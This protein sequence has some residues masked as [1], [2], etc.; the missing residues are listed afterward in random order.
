MSVST[1]SFLSLFSCCFLPSL[2]R[3]FAPRIYSP[4]SS[5]R[6]L[7]F[8]LLPLK[9]MLTRATESVLARLFFQPFS[10]PYSPRQRVPFPS[11]SSACKAV[12]S[13]RAKQIW[14]TRRTHDSSAGLSCSHLAVTGRY[15][16]TSVHQERRRAL[17]R[18]R[19][20][21]RVFRRCSCSLDTSSYS[22]GDT[23]PHLRAQA[24]RA[25]QQRRPTSCTWRGAEP[26]GRFCVNE[27][28]DYTHPFRT[29]NL[30]VRH[31]ASS[32]LTGSA[33]GSSKARC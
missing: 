3:V 30:A 29:E 33:S 11:S 18:P 16:D 1:V 32:V 17:W 20:W 27:S 9:L 6:P 24:R 26:Q 28:R 4:L 5:S 12:P 7:E 13:T 31:L 19:L 22:N 15:V 25:V 21:G 8:S 23:T 10:P 2:Y 14:T